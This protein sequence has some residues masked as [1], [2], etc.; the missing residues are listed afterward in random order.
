MLLGLLAAGRINPVERN[1]GP[2]TIGA[3]GILWSLAHSANGDTAG[4]N[5]C[6]ARQQPRDARGEEARRLREAARRGR[7]AQ[8]AE[9]RR[10]AGRLL[11]EEG[12]EQ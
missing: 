3:M 1:R 8:D 6:E 10:H 7:D 2:E 12:H 5:A 11:R 9:W 4:E